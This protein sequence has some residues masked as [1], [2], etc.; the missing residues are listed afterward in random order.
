MLT[1]ALSHGLA[2]LGRNGDSMLMHVTPREVAGLKHLAKA[3]GGEV[4]TNPH[5][6][7]PE[8]GFFDFFT[9][10]LPTAAGILLAPET[11]G[12]SLGLTGLAAEAAPIMAGMAT[13]AAVAGMKG[14]DPLM[15]GLT[16]AL[17]GYGGGNLGG[18]LSTMGGATPATANLPLTA[19]DAMKPAGF[20]DIGQGVQLG[21]FKDVVPT[22]QLSTAFGNTGDLAK[23]LPTTSLTAGMPVTTGAGATGGLD[24]LLAGADKFAS[25]PVGQWDAFKAAG[26]SGM[27][28]AGPVGMAALEAMAPEPIDLSEEE[29]KRKA[30]A[31]KYRSTD[32]NYILNLSADS[33]LRLSA[34]GAIPGSGSYYGSQSFQPTGNSYNQQDGTPAQNTPQQNYGLGRLDDL[35]NQ[36]ANAKAANEFYAA[37]GPIAFAKGGDKGMNIDGLPSLNVRTGESEAY[38]DPNAVTSVDTQKYIPGDMGLY[39]N[40]MLR[41]AD[42]KDPIYANPESSGM[43]LY[44]KNLLN[45]G[46]GKDRI[47]PVHAPSAMQEYFKMVQNTGQK[48]KMAHGGYLDGA[49]DG[50]SDSIPATIEGQQPA[51]LA[52]GEFVVPADVVSH[53]GNGSSKAGAQRLYKMLNKVRTARTGNPRQGKQINPNKYLPA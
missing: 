21:Q 40:N 32:P 31:N 39:F 18:A 50:M 3:M 13:G 49:G 47:Q 15:G 4:T 41:K 16:G 42:G 43:D 27:Q 9:S 22:D 46:Q 28:L 14:G 44:F 10:L 20:A 38:V 52:D 12:A 5:T 19:S 11:G 6:G 30:K 24:T 26:G 7:L 34:G 2:S 51:R 37:G 8:A 33:G 53:I 35:A 36:G 45:M 48:N 23:N 25:N 29:A 1:H 17:G